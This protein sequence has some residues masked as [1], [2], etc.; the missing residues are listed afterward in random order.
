VGGTVTYTEPH[1]FAD[2]TAVGPID[3]DRKDWLQQT[4]SHSRNRIRKRRCLPLSRRADHG[5]SRPD[6]G[7]I[8]GAL[9]R[10]QYQETLPFRFGS[11]AAKARTAT[12]ITRLRPA[13]AGQR[14]GSARV[15]EKNSAKVFVLK[16]R[17][18][19][20]FDEVRQRFRLTS[21]EKRVA[22]F[23][24]AAFVLGLITKCYRDAHSSPTPVQTHPGSTR[25]S[26][27]SRTEADRSRGPKAGNA[28]RRPR[29][30]A[31]KLDLSDS[32]AEHEDQ[33]R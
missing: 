23:I 24:V 5:L 21:T 9:L 1:Q 22:V 29:K 3:R 18:R 6:I 16:K 25:A 27:S 31:E 17:R 8:K 13:A 7:G 11:A 30:S 15:D 2:S 28:T 32:A 26:A 19:F 20:K 4:P 14:R 12:E 10:F 33:Q